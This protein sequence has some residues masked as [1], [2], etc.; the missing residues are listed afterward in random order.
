MLGL[1]QGESTLNS[2]KA[3]AIDGLT[4][5]FLKGAPYLSSPIILLCNL[6]ISFSTFP[7]KCKIAELKLLFKTGSTTEPKKDLLQSQKRIYYRAKK[8]S[9]TVPKKDLLQS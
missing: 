5:K 8:G 3:A 9:T 6:T 1:G 2:S 4:G 7:E